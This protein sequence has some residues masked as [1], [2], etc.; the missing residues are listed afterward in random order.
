MTTLPPSRNALRV[1]ALSLSV[2]TLLYARQIAM[3]SSAR[4]RFYYHWQR[5]DAVVLLAGLMA[6]A[7]LLY[8]VVT[9][10]QRASWGGVA[11]KWLSIPLLADIL[12]GYAGSGKTEGRFALFTAAWVLAT[13][14]GLYA[15][16]RFGSRFFD[17][18]T[19]LLT[20]FAWL[21]PILAAQ[22]LL[23]RPWDVRPT[24]QGRPEV[25]A[26]ANRIPVFLFLFDE[27]SYQRSYDGAEL[28]PFF[29]NLR[30]LARRSLE[31]TNAHSQ[32][33][34]THLS[35]PSL[36]FQREG[37]LLP[38]NGVTVWKQGD[39]TVQ[40][41]KLPS[42]FAAAEARGYRTSL[43]G[44]YFPYR[45]VLGDQVDQIIHQ[46]YAP[47]GSRFG[48]AME[49]FAARNLNFLAD[50]VSQIL[51]DRWNSRR[52]SE[53]W[54][55]I[56]HK[57]RASVRDLVRRAD[58][59]T[60]AMIHWPLPHAPFVLNEDGSYRGPFKGARMEG[61]PADYQRH[62][63]LVDVVLG[64]A[65]AEL[66]TAGLL[67]QSLVIVTSDHSWKAEPDSVRRSAPGARTWVPLIVKLPHQTTGYRIQTRFCLGQLGALLQR[68]MDTT[69]TA[70][71]RPQ[72]VEKL[73]SSTTCL[74]RRHVAGS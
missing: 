53:N 37:V 8:L 34:I 70:R 23:W 4:N 41:A 58:R 68:V 15:A 47:K 9:I 33:G 45:A 3:W 16:I 49:Y 25:T 35:I 12:V 21:A 54:F 5:S 22:A 19:T 72:E 73:P 59:N 27:W 56:N 17:R 48:W 38:Q 65:L 13:A 57:W 14:I 7:S 69:L 29:R 43:I 39:S 52:V 61:S 32:A 20:A 74:R 60:F 1:A 46:S 24:V 62:L 44:F 28:R 6:V 2:A 42:I 31:F 63:A 40:S 64:E 18:A 11:L 26:A 36:L 30:Q 51:W 67:D 10:L 50:P 71:N 66:D 55:R